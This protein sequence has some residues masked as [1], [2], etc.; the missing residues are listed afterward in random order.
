[1]FNA[2]YP[3]VYKRLRERAGLTQEE[4]GNVLGVSRYTVNK[5]EAGRARLG[6]DQERKLFEL[7]KCCKAEFG[8]LICRELSDYLGKKIGSQNGHATYEPSAALQ[9]A[10]AL[11]D[12]HDSTMSD[13]MRRSLHNRINT[14]QLMGLAYDKN[15]AELVEYARDCRAKLLV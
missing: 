15:N 1:M 14:T 4:L 9:M 13:A 2:L 6:E 3:N 8:A 10:F 7:A 12:E 5:V 11:L